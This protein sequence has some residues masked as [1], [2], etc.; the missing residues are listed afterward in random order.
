MTTVAPENVTAQGETEKALWEL[1][2]A[3]CK[4]FKVPGRSWTGERVWGDDP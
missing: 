2:N 4:A 1:R 3:V